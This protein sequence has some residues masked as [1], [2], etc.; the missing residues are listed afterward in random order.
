MQYEA[1]TYNTLG[2]SASVSIGFSSNGQTDLFQA[3]LALIAMDKECMYKRGAWTNSIVI[4][5]VTCKQHT[6]S[7]NVW[8]LDGMFLPG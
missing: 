1:N 6:I 7:Y 3:T 5:R 4:S 8:L 2:C